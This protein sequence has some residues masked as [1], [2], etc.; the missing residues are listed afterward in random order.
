MIEI[1]SHGNVKRIRRKCHACGCEFEFGERD[2]K[3]LSHLDN[4]AGMLW[5]RCPDCGQ[6]L[7][8]CMAEIESPENVMNISQEIG[9]KNEI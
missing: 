5:L 4:D 1:I 6:V 2:L 7:F 8:F 3:N 9:G